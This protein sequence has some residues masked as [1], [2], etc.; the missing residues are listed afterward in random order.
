MWKQVLTGTQ[1]LQINS[2]STPIATYIIVPLLI[3]PSMQKRRVTYVFSIVPT[4]CTK[5]LNTYPA[6]GKYHYKTLSQGVGW[7]NIQAEESGK[8]INKN[9]EK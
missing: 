9:S 3:Q 6:I 4:D 7:G 5:Y 2:S 1:L 8:T